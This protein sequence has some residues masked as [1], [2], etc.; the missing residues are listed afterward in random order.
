MNNATPS[1]LMYAYVATMNTIFTVPAAVAAS[2]V[3]CRSFVSLANF[4]HKDIYVHS[5]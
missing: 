1:E 2:I 4:L 5:I 3:A